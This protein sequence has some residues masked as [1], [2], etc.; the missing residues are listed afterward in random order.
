MPGGHTPALPVSVPHKRN[1]AP[2]WFSSGRGE[3]SSGPSYSFGTT[4]R[5][6]NEVQSYSL[7]LKGSHITPPQRT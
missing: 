3:F 5:S 6:M 7:K 4:P 2:A 1:H